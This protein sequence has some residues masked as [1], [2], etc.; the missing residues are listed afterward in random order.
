MGGKKFMLVK[1]NP[2]SKSAYLG[3]EGGGGACV[4]ETATAL[5]IGIWD[6]NSKMSNGQ[7][8]NP[9]DCNE[10]VEKTAEF[11]RTQGY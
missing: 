3:R 11:L 4:A 1:H 5:V 6:K 8:Q 9:G 7:L 2:E 10:L